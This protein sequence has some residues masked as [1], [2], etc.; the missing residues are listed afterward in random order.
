MNNTIC[1]IRCQNKLRIIRGYK[2]SSNLAAIFT[3]IYKIVSQKTLQADDAQAKGPGEGQTIV[4][5][6]PAEE[7]GKKKSCC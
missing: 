4:V 2:Q 1:V 5:T 7:G 3:Q 6:Q